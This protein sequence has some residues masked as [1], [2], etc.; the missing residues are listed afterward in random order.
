MEII[1]TSLLAF[2][3]LLPLVVADLRVGFYNATCPQAE[4]IKRQVVQRRFATDSSITGGLLHVHFHDCSIRVSYILIL[5]HIFYSF[6]DISILI[7]S[8]KKKSSKKSAGPNLIVRGYKLIDEIEKSLEVVCPSIVSSA[9]IVTLATRDSVVLAGGPRYVAPTDAVTGSYQTQTLLTCPVHHFQRL[10][11]RNLSL[12]KP[13]TLKAVSEISESYLGYSSYSTRID[14]LIPQDPALVSKL[15]TLC[16]ASNNSSTFLDQNTSSTFDNQFY[17]QILLRRG[18]LQIDQE[19]ASDT[20]TVGIVSG[21]ASNSLRF[22]SR[23][24]LENAAEIRKNCRVFNPAKP[25][26]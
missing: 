1:K 12:P 15:S 26:N 7:D 24:W 6:C 17:N 14:L 10:R 3:F 23:C 5:K 19:L 8:T 9:D 11:L 2:F 25:K 4:S 22:I 13:M 18:V 21:F 16:V 20:S